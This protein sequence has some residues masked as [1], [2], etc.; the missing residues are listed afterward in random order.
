MPLHLPSSAW[1]ALRREGNNAIREEWL[2]AGLNKGGGEVACIKNLIEVG[3]PKLEAAWQPIIGHHNLKVGI[4]GA[5]C[6][7][8]PQVIFQGAKQGV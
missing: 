1:A 3:L 2:A 4:A 7:P 5:V 8:I 6:H